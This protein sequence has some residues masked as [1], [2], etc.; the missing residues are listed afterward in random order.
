METRHILLSF[1]LNNKSA[2]QTA[3]MYKLIC[4][5]VVCMAL[6]ELDD[7]SSML[8]NKNVARFT[9]Y[10]SLISGPQVIKRFSCSTQ[11]S[12]KFKSSH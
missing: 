3:H 1:V 5:Y 7:H 10:S 9:I 8:M 2:N 4:A 6:V 12:M 11:L